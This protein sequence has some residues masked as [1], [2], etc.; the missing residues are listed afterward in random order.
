MNREEILEAL[1]E[2]IHPETGSDIVSGGIVDAVNITEE[3]TVVHL[4]FARSRDPFAAAIKRQ[5]SERLAAAGRVTVVIREQAP[6]RGEP[7]P[8]P[9][10]AGKISCILAIASGKGGVG[11]STV[12]SNLAVTLAAGGYRVGLLDADI[13]G[14]SQPTM[15]GVEGY[16]PEVEERDGGEYIIPAE[17][18]GVKLIS[19]G[20]F[21]DSRDALIWRGPMATNAL[22]Q[23]IHQTLWGELDFLLVDM[24]PG[25]GDVH[26]GVISELQLTGAIVVTTPQ[27]VALA[28]V[29]RGVNMF[30]APKIEVPVLGIVENMSWFTPAELPQNR[31][32]IF[33]R[34]GAA[35]LAAGEG[36]ELLGQIPVVE[37]V[38]TGGDSGRPAVLSD[39]P[40]NDYYRQLADRIV[41]KTAISCR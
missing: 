28:D 27:Q 5:V 38:V 12:A 34:G 19:I 17:R 31:Y 33:G 18:Y 29:L 4:L 9:S 6:K 37:S 8:A 13:Y 21:I 1:S 32:Y 20:F 10:A 25:T 14:P 40:V 16:R 35:H 39:S 36:L 26:L 2:I 3:G 7:I 23:M 30:R 24:P 41:E 22:R 15:F 11:K